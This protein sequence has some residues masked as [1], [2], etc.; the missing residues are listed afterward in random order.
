PTTRL[1]NHYEALPLSEEARKTH[2]NVHLSDLMDFI[3]ICSVL[4]VVTRRSLVLSSE[5]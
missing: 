2:C 3:D 5:I 1:L 4:N